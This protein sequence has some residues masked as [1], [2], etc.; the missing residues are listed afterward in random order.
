MLYSF[1][2]TTW[3]VIS[4]FM[5]HYP[6][7][8]AGFMLTTWY[9]IPKNILLNVLVSASFMLTTWYVIASNISKV[10]KFAFKFYANYV[11]CN[12]S[13]TTY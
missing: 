2:L 1:I 5:K 13:H 11:V 12:C 3:Y 10:L 4:V 9:V 8:E 6:K 7:Y